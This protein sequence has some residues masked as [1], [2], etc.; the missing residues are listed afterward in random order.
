MCDYSD[1]T[2]YVLVIVTIGRPKSR[3][4]CD[5]GV[6]VLCTECSLNVHWHPESEERLKINP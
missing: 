5:K 4:D 6:A 1:I 2:T 3:N